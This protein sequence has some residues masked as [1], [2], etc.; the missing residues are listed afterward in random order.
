MASFSSTLEMAR[1]TATSKITQRG[2]PSL[3]TIFYKEDTLAS[4][5]K[6]TRSKHGRGEG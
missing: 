1:S 6:Q 3:F 4:T 5:A 2:N